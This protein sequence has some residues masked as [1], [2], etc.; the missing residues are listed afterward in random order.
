MTSF[1]ANLSFRPKNDLVRC[2]I[3][4]LLIGTVLGAGGT[5]AAAASTSSDKATVVKALAD[6]SRQLRLG[7]SAVVTDDFG[8]LTVAF[9]TRGNR[10]TTTRANGQ[11]LTEVRVGKRIAVTT[12][13]LRYWYF[14][15]AFGLTSTD[16]TAAVS[17]RLSSVSG[18]VDV[19]DASSDADRDL[20]IFPADMT[21]VT[22]S[23]FAAVIGAVRTS[24][25]GIYKTY[26]TRV[27]L[28]TMTIVV[29]RS[30]KV[31]SIAV[32]G[33]VKRKIEYRYEP[34]S[35]AVPTTSQMQSLDQISTTLGLPL[36]FKHAN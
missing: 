33:S 4:S 13:T 12:S 36:I 22:P 29:D 28:D 20:S 9:D 27:G 34:V 1:M 11:E 2:A 6:S 14:E 5:S 31:R 24:T 32:N 35:F 10:K 26:S 15:R 16:I 30:N 19:T 21:G 7:G 25:S 3:A 18:F 17:K 8:K 23:S